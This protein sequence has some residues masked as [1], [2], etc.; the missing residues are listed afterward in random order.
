MSRKSE[1][2][3]APK[4][5]P[6]AARPPNQPHHDHPQP[7]ARLLTLG[8]EEESDVYAEVETELRKGDLSVA[9]S[10]LLGMVLDE[11]YYD[12]YEEKVNENDPRSWTRLHAVRVLARC[13]P[14]AQTA[15]QPLLPLL[16]EE[17][18]Y[19]REEMPFVYAAIG[20]PAIEPLACLVNDAEA[21]TWLRGGAGESLS[22]IG[23]AHPELRERVI[24][25]LEQALINE[26]EDETL[27]G[28]LVM[29]LLDLGAKE[30]LPII[31]QA[32]EEERVDESVVQLADVEEHF[33]LPRVTPR[34][35]WNYFPEDNDEEEESG[36]F[37]G[38]EEEAEEEEA[39]QQPYVAPIKVG[40]N[41]PC[42]CGSGKKYKKCHGA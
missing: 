40:R 18:D 2:R 16:N 31:Q 9:I 13:G 15:I 22:E 12:Y 23:Q 41:D 27:C 34:K 35:K 39:P 10:T 21:D 3:P 7:Y 20:E 37:V 6:P 26:K 11:T 29:N 42:P 24:A 36:I 19:L 38:D 14:D 8:E 33:G 25:P 4:P 32:F 30:S 1:R 17:D 28:F 5:K